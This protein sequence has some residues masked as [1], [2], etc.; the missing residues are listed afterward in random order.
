[1]TL[2]DRTLKNVYERKERCENTAQLLEGVDLQKLA[3]VQNVLAKFRNLVP[4]EATIFN[5]AIEDAKTDLESYRQGGVKQ[6]FKNIMSDPVLKATSFANAIR[7]GLANL[8][9][10]ARIYMP[11]GAEKE[12][13]RSVLE[14]IPQEK[15]QQFIEAMTKA[16]APESKVDVKALFTGNAMPYVQNL[17]AAVQ[18]LLQNTN[19]Q[20]AF[21][22]SN[23]IQTVPA[24]V[25]QQASQPNQQQPTNA[26]APT[27]TAAASAPQQTTNTTP[28]QSAAA[29]QKPVQ[30]K[31]PTRVAP[32]DKAAITDMAAYLTKKVG[33]DQASL[34]R[35]LTQLAK[36][37]K[38]MS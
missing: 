20:A 11:Q 38:L 10:I 13:Q 23:Q 17:Q 3:A 35:V 4:Q 5:K 30:S 37:Q 7:D 33:L 8:P 27:P 25:V 1:M 26:A 18:E 29:A 28:T 24:P 34:E 31:T 22:M 12:T 2:K 21:K 36:D 9:A 6:F 32:D 15:Q 16:F 14:M 19:P